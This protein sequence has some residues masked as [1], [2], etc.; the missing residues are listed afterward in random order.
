[1]TFWEVQDV[2]NYRTIEEG[3]MSITSILLWVKIL[4]F[5]RI[6]QQFGILIRIIL[7]MISNVII[8]LII[9][10]VIVI[11]FALSF[12]VVIG[13]NVD[14]FDSFGS[15]ILT[16]FRITYGQFDWSGI[17]NSHNGLAVALY[18]LYVTTSA[19]LLL[20]LLIAMLNQSYTQ[21]ISSA[22]SEYMI[23]KAGIIL[24]YGSNPVKTIEVEEESPVPFYEISIKN[25]QPV[26]KVIELSSSDDV[27]RDKSDQTNDMLSDSSKESVPI[28]SE[29]KNDGEKKDEKKDEEKKEEKTEEKKRKDRRKERK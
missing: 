29:P 26:E 6:I 16:L 19:I 9:F 10:M 15:S 5:I 4:K 21:V 25:K 3:F 1:M 12:H 14:S 22:K 13:A 8:F 18:F 24:T 27:E 11:G 7:K 28:S 17:Q 2:V 20:N 23:E